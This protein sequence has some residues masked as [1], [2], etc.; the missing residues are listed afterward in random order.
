MS[1]SVSAEKLKEKGL[2]HAEPFQLE[3]SL[4]LLSAA[5]QRLRSRQLC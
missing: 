1:A 5:V 4:F 2:R 3:K